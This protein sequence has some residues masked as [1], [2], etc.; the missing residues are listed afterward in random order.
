MLGSDKKKSIFVCRPLARENNEV[1]WKHSRCVGVCRS[2]VLCYTSH[3]NC[4]FYVGLS[5]DFADFLMSSCLTSCDVCGG[6]FN[7]HLEHK[8][9]HRNLISYENNCTEK[10]C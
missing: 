7:R 8:A 5:L 6:E 4:K 1:V 9:C 10:Y 2:G 3:F